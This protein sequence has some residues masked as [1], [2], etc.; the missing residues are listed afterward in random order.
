M[1]IRIP[2]LLSADD[3]PLTELHAL[4]LDGVVVSVDC[5]FA[6]I[7]EVPGALQRANA[8]AA[9]LHDRLVAEQW[10]AAWVWGAR[11]TPPVPHQF[12]VGLDARVTHSTAPWLALREVVIDP[13]DVFQVGSLGVTTPRRTVADLARFSPTWRSEER[14]VVAALIEVGR[15]TRHELEREL[16]RNKLPHKK[17]ARERLDLSPS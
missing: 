15:V 6:P 9:D 10:T 7:D 17:R 4:R 14:D 5:L 12:C 1:A 11:V 13:S 3:L 2:S 16:D 8:L